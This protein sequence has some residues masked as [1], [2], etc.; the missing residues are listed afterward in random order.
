MS[1]IKSLSVGNGDM[2]YVNHNS[3][4]FSMID[5][6]ITDERKSEILDEVKKLAGKKGRRSF[7]QYAPG[8]RS[9]SGY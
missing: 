3:D 8:P 1:E 5:C 7:Y 4:N 2:F 6:N 9:Y